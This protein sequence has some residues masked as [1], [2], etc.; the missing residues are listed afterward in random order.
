[1]ASPARNAFYAQLAQCTLTGKVLDLGG[2][3]KS[4]YHELIKGDHTFEVVNI[5]DEYGYDH[6]FDLE[7]PFPLKDASYDAVIA[8]N[9]LEHIYN[10]HN[11]LSESHRVLTSGGTLVVAVPF[12]MFVHPSPHDYFRYTSEA[13]TR[14]C[15]DAGFKEVLVQPLGR[16]PGAVFVQLVGGM[17]SGAVVRRFVA[18]FMWIFDMKARLFMSKHALAEQFPLG[19]I[20]TAKK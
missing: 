9:L 10:Y 13:L 7:E 1:M 18:P 20:V 11:V 15:A 4:G 14:M 6:K 2:S 19:Y 12:L 5:S 16:G 8:V 3:K 17:R